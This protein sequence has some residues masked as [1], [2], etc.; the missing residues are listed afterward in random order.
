M[1]AA[2]EHAHEI[3]RT[4]VR[5]AGV[6]RRNDDERRQR[7]DRHDLATLPRSG[8]W[9]DLSRSG[10]ERQSRR[11]RSRIHSVDLFVMRRAAFTP[12]RRAR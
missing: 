5:R 12:N 7:P 4:D 1:S 6:Q 9:F 2:I 8:N 10:V 11:S 3:D